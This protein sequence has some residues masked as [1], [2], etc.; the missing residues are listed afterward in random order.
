MMLEPSNDFYS[1]CSYNWCDAS[2]GCMKIVKVESRRIFRHNKRIQFPN[3]TSSTKYNDTPSPPTEWGPPR[4]TT[5]S[6]MTAFQSS[7]VRIWNT[8]NMAFQKSSKFVLGFSSR[9]FWNWAPNNCIPSR[10]NMTMK[11]NNRNKRLRID[12]ILPNSDVIKLRSDA[13]YLK[14]EEDKS[15]GLFIWSHPAGTDTRWGDLDVLK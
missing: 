2:L 15:W 14:K 6:Y 11:R 5:P 10:A 9:T 3:T 13:Q 4:A 8:A 12:F 7:P 1:T